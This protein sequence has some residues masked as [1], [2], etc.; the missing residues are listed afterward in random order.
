MPP[1]LAI[2]ILPSYALKVVKV[3]T[4]NICSQVQINVMY[5]YMILPAGPVLQSPVACL[6]GLELSFLERLRYY[7]HRKSKFLSTALL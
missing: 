5:D 4:I 7:G 2:I 1:S 6:H 3:R